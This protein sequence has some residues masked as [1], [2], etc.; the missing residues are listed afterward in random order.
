M[1][2][3]VST[4]ALSWVPKPSEDVEYTTNRIGDETMGAHLL[5]AMGASFE[6]LKKTSTV[7]FLNVSVL[8]SSGEFKVPPVMSLPKCGMAVGRRMACAQC[9]VSCIMCTL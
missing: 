6:A 1:N 8:I 5:P 4:I 3:L 9:I 2:G 7:G